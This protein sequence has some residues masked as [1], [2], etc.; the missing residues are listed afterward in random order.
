MPRTFP[1]RLPGIFAGGEAYLPVLPLGPHPTTR[2]AQKGP[3]VHNWW[4]PQGPER[5]LQVLAGRQAVR[6]V[7]KTGWGATAVCLAIGSY[8]H[9]PTEDGDALYLRGEGNTGHPQLGRETST[10]FLSQ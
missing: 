2:L 3:L 8:P 9:M 7:D 4:L 5:F 6:P 10:S 1:G